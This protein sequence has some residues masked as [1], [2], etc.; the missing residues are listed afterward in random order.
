M[1]QDN[2]TIENPYDNG[3]A[4]QELIKMMRRKE[5]ITVSFVVDKYGYA[6]AKLDSKTL[7]EPF[8]LQ[9]NEELYQWLTDY[10]VKG[11][12]TEPI[13]NA[14]KD[15]LKALAKD[16]NEL[17]TNTLINYISRDA[18]RF[19]MHVTPE[20]ADKPNMLTV[21]FGFP[22]GIIVFKVKRE[23]E[24]LEELALIDF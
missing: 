23:K 20:I 24:I 13:P 15:R 19:H 7:T 10:L 12:I 21:K 6:C 17:A 2:T 16:S 11:E 5:K 18:F 3:K 9:M 8:I 1:N 22:N 4:L 14:N